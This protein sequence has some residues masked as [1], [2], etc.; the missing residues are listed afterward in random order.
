MKN[1]LLDITSN[2]TDPFVYRPV[3]ACII[4]LFNYLC[5]MNDAKF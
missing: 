3:E 2:H 1:V 5:K 4:C